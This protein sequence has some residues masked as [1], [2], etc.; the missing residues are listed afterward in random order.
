AAVP[1]CQHCP[2]GDRLV[3]RRQ[4]HVGTPRAERHACIFAGVSSD[5]SN[6]PT[7]RLGQ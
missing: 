1:D 4:T 6:A 7:A 5:S 3:P 2:H